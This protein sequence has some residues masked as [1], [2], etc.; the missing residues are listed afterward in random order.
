MRARD[1]ESSGQLQLNTAETTRDFGHL[2]RLLSEHL[3]RTALAAPVGEISLAAGDVIALRED[4]LSLLPQ[5]PDQAKEPLQQLLERI[6]VRLGPDCVRVGRLRE[7]SPARADAVLGTLAGPAAAP[8]AAPRGRPSAAELA[9]RPAIAPSIQAW[10]SAAT[11]PST[12]VRC[13]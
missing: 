9:A 10:A 13:S 12:G 4:S 7:G 11:S 2:S 3:A 1:V 6:A 5:S 8:H